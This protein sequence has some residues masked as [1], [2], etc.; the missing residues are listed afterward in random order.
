MPFRIFPALLFFA[1]GLLAPSAVR[2]QSPI[3]VHAQSLEMNFPQSMR[4]ILEAQ[5]ASPIQVARLTV[6]QRG[7][8]LGSRYAPPFTPGPT[9]RVAYEWNFQSFARGGFLPPGTHGE[10]TWHIEDAAGNIYDT[11][12]Q[13]YIVQDNSRNW[14][15]LA[16][17][18]LR[19]S[20]HSGS[21]SFGKAVLDRAV[22]AQRFLANELQIKNL[23]PLEIFIYADTQEFFNAL[24][25]YVH[26]WTGGSTFPEYGVIMINFAPDNL[27]WGLRATSHEL[28]HAILHSKIRGEL[29]AISLALWLDEGLAVYNETDNHSADKQFQAAYENAL[30]R[31]SLIP[32]R[33]LERRFPSDSNQAQLAYGQSYEIVK[34]MI[35]EYGEAKFGKLL[36]TYQKGALPD[37]G[38]TLVYGMNQDQLENAWRA[39]IGAPLRDVTISELPTLAPRPTFEFSSPLSNTPSPAAA[40]TIEPTRVPGAP[41]SQP[42]RVSNAN[43]PASNPTSVSESGASPSGATPL[44][45]VGTAPN[46]TRVSSAGASSGDSAPSQ[47]PGIPPLSFCGGGALLLI[48]LCTLS[49]LKR[50]RLT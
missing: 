24:P 45:G 49:L 6:W 27:D 42:T 31:N 48:G 36:D 50:R 41:P 3:V 10:Y 29:G 33:K 18:S 46:T 19:V 2:A 5:S 35:E 1:L 38:L 8:G 7:V 12:H 14:Q 28:S 22:S 37:A 13:P 34:F 25:S 30:R 11:P 9:V 43:T 16:N 32:L 23:D 15:V 20:W 44:S 17:D 4:F 39:K 21:A 47:A 26:E 40:L